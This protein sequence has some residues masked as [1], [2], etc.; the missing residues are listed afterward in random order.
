MRVKLTK[1]SDGH[2]QMLTTVDSLPELFDLLKSFRED[3]SRFILDLDETP[4][5]FM[6]YDDYI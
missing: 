5:E 6:I 2:W 4:V 1:A 3:S